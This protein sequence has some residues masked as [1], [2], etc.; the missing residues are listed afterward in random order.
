MAIYRRGKIWWYGFEFEGRRIQESSRFKN[1]TAALRA[2]AKRRAELLDRRAGFARTSL[3]P[4]FEEF[5]AEFLAWSERQHR[6][7]TRALHALNCGTLQRFFG[8]RWLDEISARMV[9]D[10]KAARIA[11]GRRNERKGSSRPRT[12]AGATVNRALST[13]RLIF[14]YAERCGYRLANPVRGVKFFPETGRMRVV[15]FEEELAYMRAASQPLRDIARV[16]LDTGLR[17]EEVF[18]L[19]FSGLD[20]ERGTIFNPQGKTPAARRTVTM[21]QDVLR[22]LERRAAA[23]KARYVFPSPECAD[24]PIGS[25]R[26]AHDAAVRRAG[27]PEPFRLYDLRHTYA[28]RAAMAGVDLPTLAALLGHS[29]IQMTMRYVHPAEEHKREAAAK[30]E[31]FNAAGFLKVAERTAAATTVPSTSGRVN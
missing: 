11:E 5:A 23:A 6:R 29:T 27:I 9:E 24:R 13:L 10:F 1:K 18:R 20:L 19:E 25:V 31:G 26:K 3:P 16:I 12:V 4:K 15:S 22:I 28:S 2:E 21:S 7:K 30:V 17:P 14:N 8:G